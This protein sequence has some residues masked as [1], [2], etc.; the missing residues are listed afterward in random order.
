MT[1]EEKSRVQLTE[2]ILANRIPLY[3]FILAQIP[4]AHTAE[5]LFQEVCLVI[6]E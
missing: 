4:N 5:D 2:L 1:S 3:G 6:S